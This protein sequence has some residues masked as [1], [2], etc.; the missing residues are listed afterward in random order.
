M[1]PTFRCM[2]RGLGCRVMYRAALGW[3]ASLSVIDAA[4]AAA[5]MGVSRGLLAD[6]SIACF[7]G[8]GW[9]GGWVCLWAAWACFVRPFFSSF[10]FFL[11]PNQR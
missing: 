6:R 5:P 1:N 3:G 7:A 4:A 8:P 11:H 2:L 10:F 9:D